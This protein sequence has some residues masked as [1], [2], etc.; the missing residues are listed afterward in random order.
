GTCAE[1]AASTARSAHHRADAQR[2]RG[3]RRRALKVWGCP[4]ELRGDTMSMRRA[5]FLTGATLLWVVGCGGVNESGL[6]AMPGTGGHRAADAAIV[7][8]S[9]AQPPHN[10]T[11]PP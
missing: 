3:P 4:A 10:M 7:E 8:H 2:W 5:G 9:D 6:T 11:V 1:T